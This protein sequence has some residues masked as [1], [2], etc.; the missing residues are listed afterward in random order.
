MKSIRIVRPGLLRYGASHFGRDHL[1]S[2]NSVAS[3]VNRDLIDSGISVDNFKNSIVVLDFRGEGHDSTDIEN[4]VNYLQ[5][6]PVQKV[7]VIFNAKVD[8]A[9]LNYSAISAIDSMANHCQW[10]EKLQ[11]Y[12]QILDTECN[13]LCLLR[14][15]SQSRARLAASLLNS[16]DSLRISFGSM[17]QPFQL[18]E[19]IDLFGNVSL[20][21]LLDGSSN[22]PDHEYHQVH[23]VLFR[24]CAVNIIA[25]S[26]SQTD[27][28]VWRSVFVTEKTFKAFG[29]MQIPIWWAVPG[30]VN[31]VRK[32]G[33][34]VFDDVIDHSYDQ[35]HC[36][37][38]RFQL[39][40]TQV[41]QLETLNL[42]Q[43]RQE[44]KSRLEANH[45]LLKRIVQDQ[46]DH[47]GQLLK[48][49]DLDNTV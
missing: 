28:G 24:T 32:L 22:L 19:Y 37:D 17:Y 29:M 45:Q 4:L 44:L 47:F 11:Q 21:I 27:V 34:D 43:L 48:Y 3:V 30:V 16:V 38:Q 31:C 10:F 1:A 36:E 25:E 26:S 18:K 23:N 40:L 8:V 13:F 39:L 5:N 33:F 46:Q 49:L 35:E 42:T 15:P 2:E 41:K 7:A 20:P 12:P 6:V 9:T 14:R